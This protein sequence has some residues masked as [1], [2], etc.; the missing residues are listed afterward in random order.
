VENEKGDSA[1]P[2]ANSSV[3]CSMNMALPDVSVAL[4]MNRAS[5]DSKETSNDVLPGEDTD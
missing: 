4:S 3:A 5:S 1:A 2:L